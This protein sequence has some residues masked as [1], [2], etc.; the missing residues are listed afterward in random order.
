ML[1]R[2][3]EI[4]AS[5]IN[6]SEQYICLSYSFELSVSFQNVLCYNSGILCTP[7]ITCLFQDAFSHSVRIG[8][9]KEMILL[10]SSN[11]STYPGIPSIFKRL[12]RSLLQLPSA[13]SSRFAIFSSKVRSLPSRN[14]ILLSEKSKVTKNQIRIKT[15]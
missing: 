4:F 14:K 13:T 7:N 6:W 8:L 9:P 2:I 11:H 3:S 12:Q 5:V 1:C 10:S 15:T